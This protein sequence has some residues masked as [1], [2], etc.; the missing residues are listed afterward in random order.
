M[1]VSKTSFRHNYSDPTIPSP[2]LVLSQFDRFY[3]KILAKTSL[4]MLAMQQ[5]GAQSEARGT[6]PDP[7]RQSMAE[8]ESR[9][10]PYTSWTRYWLFRLFSVSKNAYPQEIDRGDRRSHRST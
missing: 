1:S 10:V 6:I 4:H 9:V 7:S 3:C 2:P 8:D 5:T